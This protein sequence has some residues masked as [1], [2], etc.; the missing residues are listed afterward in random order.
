MGLRD[1]CIGELRQYASAIRDLTQAVRDLLAY[2]E[3]KELRDDNRAL[4]STQRR[5][6]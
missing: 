3:A 5:R 4:M 1:E 6:S 2:L